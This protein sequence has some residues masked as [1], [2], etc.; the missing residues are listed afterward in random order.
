[1][2]AW[3]TNRSSFAKVNA[4]LTKELCPAYDKQKVS[5]FMLTWSTQ[6]SRM[7]TRKSRRSFFAAAG[8]LELCVGL[9]APAH[10]LGDA[11]LFVKPQAQTFSPTKSAIVSPETRC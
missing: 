5:G 6:H 2:A 9:R 11:H 10:A 7:G 4:A 1:M 3:F 8:S